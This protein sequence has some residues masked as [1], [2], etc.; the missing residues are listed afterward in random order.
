MQPMTVRRCTDFPNPTS[1]VAHI[2]G[3]DATGAGKSMIVLFAP[4]GMT[5]QIPV[6]L[7]DTGVPL[8]LADRR[9]SGR[10]KYTVGIVYYH[11]GVGPSQRNKRQ[12]V[13]FRVI[14]RKCGGCG[15]TDQQGGIGNQCLVDHLETNP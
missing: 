12:A 7:T 14:E 10:W 11:H 6:A 3:P 5:A 2:A 15:N 13:L 4:T 1:I 8:M 9:Y